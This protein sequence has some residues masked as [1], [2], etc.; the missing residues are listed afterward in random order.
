[1]TDGRATERIV[2]VGMGE[3]ADAL[4]MALARDGRPTDLVADPLALPWALM[5]ETALAVEALPDDAWNKRSAVGTLLN[6]LP[7]RVPLAIAT[8]RHSLGALLPA[9]RHA[10]RVV[11]LHLVPGSS[12]AE[13]AMPA[14][15][16][17]EV[18]DGVLAL[19]GARG[20]VALPCGDVPGRIVDRLVAAAW[21][22]ARSAAATG[23]SDGDVMAAFADAGLSLA[24]LGPD[25]D[26]LTLI[27][28]IHAGLGE[29]DRYDATIL[30]SNGARPV[31]ATTLSERVTL[32]VIAEAYRLVEEAVAGAAEIERAMTAG[33][34]WL[35]GPFTLAGCR[36]LRAVV[37]GLTAIAR[38]PAEDAATH[39][40]YALPRVLWTMATV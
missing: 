31:G 32:A 11:G 3:S 35:S 36:G 8:R 38:D 40:R 26:A 9:S 37:A 25:D 16:D 28:A 33:A 7:V 29:P 14:Q 20:L 21:L 23:A 4:A 10:S 1:V 27:A 30:R 5:A 12:V 13:V 17:G 2:V 24:A 18:V 39:D 15:F 22:E 34:G 19:L 6:V